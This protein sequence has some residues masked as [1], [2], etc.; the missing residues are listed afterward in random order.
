MKKKE[1]KVSVKRQYMPFMITLTGPQIE[2]I[3]QTAQET[4]MKA[5]EFV[6]TVFDYI[7]RYKGK[8]IK[9]N[10]QKSHIDTLLTTAQK[11]AEDAQRR[12]EELAKQKE[13]LGA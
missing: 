7:M 2:W 8:D 4:E 1:R 3:K 11:D 6:R 5:T 10:L 9:S 12:V 13:A